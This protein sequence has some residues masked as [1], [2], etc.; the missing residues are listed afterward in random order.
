[1]FQIDPRI[2]ARELP[3]NLGFQR[4][5]FQ[6]PCGNF[7]SYRLTAYCNL[8]FD[9]CPRSAPLFQPIRNTDTGLV[10]LRFSLAGQL[11]ENLA[12]I[13]VWSRDE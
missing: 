10:G 11:H 4:V 13:R 1:M 7:L 12:E 6:F 5:S 3:A 2:V 8:I 9:A